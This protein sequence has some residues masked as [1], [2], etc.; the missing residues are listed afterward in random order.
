MT[1]RLTGRRFRLSY[2]LAPTYHL[3][4]RLDRPISLSSILDRATL[5]IVTVGSSRS[6]LDHPPGQLPL[7]D[8][9][10]LQEPDVGDPQ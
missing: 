9:S 6:A 8:L 3:P 5:L 4:L 2:L 7:P 1:A 10:S